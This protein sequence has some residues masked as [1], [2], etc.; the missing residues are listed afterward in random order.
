MAEENRKIQSRARELLADKSQNDALGVLTCE[1]PAVSIWRLKAR[2]D[3]VVRQLHGEALRSPGGQ[4]GN[5]NASKDKAKTMFSVRLE[6]DVIE[7]IGD[8]AKR[9]GISQAGYI[10]LLVNK[11]KPLQMN[12][13][14][15]DLNT[16]SLSEELKRR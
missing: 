12:Y 11:D 13:Q 4:P 8:R 7:L 1:F 6:R 14:D 15:S 5:Q 3:K 16:I 9:L 10:K 2:L